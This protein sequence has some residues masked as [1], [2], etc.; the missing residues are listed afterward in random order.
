MN[1]RKVKRICG[2]RGCKNTDS[3]MI[4]RTREVG[5]SVIIC[6]ECLKEGLKAVGDYV[7]A[8][9]RASVPPPPLFFN[10]PVPEAVSNTNVAVDTAEMAVKTQVEET[11]AEFI[12]PDCGKEFKSAAGLQSHMRTHKEGDE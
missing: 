3:F 1:I 10:D 7:P 2:V 12:C 5:N 8:P 9:R 11:A 6:P 4:S